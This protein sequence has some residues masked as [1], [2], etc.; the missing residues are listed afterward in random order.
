MQKITTFLWFDTQAEEAVDYYASIFKDLKKVKVVRWME[1]GPG[2]AGAVLTVEFTIFG[3]QFVALNGGPEFKFNESVSFLINCDT[4]EEVD[5]YWNALTKEGA[6][7]MC[8][9]LKDKY[10]VSWQITPK[11]LLEMIADKD[12]KKAAN[13]MRVMMTMKK[14]EIAPLRK[15]YEEV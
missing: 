4:Q 10:G 3:Q 12:Q 6:E 9:W 11:G 15:A 14:L 5:Y 8:G 7:S 1:G 13:V 2:P